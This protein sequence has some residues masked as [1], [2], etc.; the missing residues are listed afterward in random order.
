M[1]SWSIP[2]FLFVVEKPSFPSLKFVQIGVD[3]FVGAVPLDIC[4]FVP[5]AATWALHPDNGALRAENEDLKLEMAD[6]KEKQADLV[7]CWDWRVDYH[8]RTDGNIT[9]DECG[10]F[11]CRVIPYD[12]ECWVF[13]SGQYASE[14]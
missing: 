9:K 10:N 3:P 11:T 5:G 6:L 13:S 12:I 1:G 14:N 8:Q 7:N 4:W 2:E